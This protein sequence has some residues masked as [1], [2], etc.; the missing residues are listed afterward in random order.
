MDSFEEEINQD[1]T[2]L[3]YCKETTFLVQKLRE[4]EQILKSKIDSNIATEEEKK[5]YKDIGLQLENEYKGFLASTE[6]IDKKIPILKIFSIFFFIG[7][8]IDKLVGLKQIYNVDSE[9]LNYQQKIDLLESRREKYILKLII[10]I[11]IYIL[12]AIILTF[13]YI[14]LPQDAEKIQTAII[15]VFVVMSIVVCVGFG[16]TKEA[17]SSDIKHCFLNPTFKK[18]ELLDKILNSKGKI[19]W[20]TLLFEYD[21]EKNIKKYKDETGKE[22]NE[23]DL[24]LQ[25]KYD[26]KYEC[27]ERAYFGKKEHP[28]D[29]FSGI[30]KGVKFSFQKYNNIK[31][32]EIVFNASVIKIICNLDYKNKLLIKQKKYL[33]YAVNLVYKNM[34]ESDC[35][36]LSNLKIFDDK[37]E[38]YANNAAFVKKVLTLD[39]IKFLNKLENKYSFFFF[40][41][42]LYVMPQAYK[43]SFKL[44]K[45]HKPTSSHE[46]FEAFEKD[47]REILDIVGKA[48]A[49]E[50][51]AKATEEDYKKFE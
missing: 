7:E 28:S 5:E 2:Y 1:R 32:D 33:D 23:L 19:I 47:M 36:K 22:Y 18:S 50:Y 9:S 6:S 39:F 38:V 37:R 34:F 10:E 25:A 44:G 12:A 42:N 41:G 16:M 3:E 11:V 51:V 43:F 14:L 26:I 27:D 20:D 49:I 17:F 31:R 46:Q 15:F 29:E 30:Y 21:R 35:V 8:K 48:K 13:L 4:K 40:D 24:R 45:L